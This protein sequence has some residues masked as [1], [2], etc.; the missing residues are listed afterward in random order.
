MEH[1]LIDTN[2]HK[3]GK[4]ECTRAYLSHYFNGIPVKLYRCDTCEKERWI[5]ADVPRGTLM[6]IA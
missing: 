2:C 4:H 3:C 5:N 6:N 1:K